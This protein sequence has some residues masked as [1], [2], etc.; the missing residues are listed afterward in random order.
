MA[1]VKS[2]VYSKAKRLNCR[3]EEIDGDIAIYSPPGFKFAGDEVHYSSWEVAHTPKAEIWD[4]FM[5]LMRRGLMA[6]DCCSEE[7][8]K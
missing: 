6:C 7:V 3:I 1:I 5:D 4:E 8:A 2:H